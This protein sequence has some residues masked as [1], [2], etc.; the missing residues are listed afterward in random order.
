MEKRRDRGEEKRGRRG[1]MEKKGG[2]CVFGF[3][4]KESMSVFILILVFLELFLGE[5]N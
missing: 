2:R 3:E 4:I 5:N 1:G